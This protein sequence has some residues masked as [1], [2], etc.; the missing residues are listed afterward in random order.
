VLPIE[1]DRLILR[2]LEVGDRDWLVALYA[3]SGGS[4]DDAARELTEALEH[5]RAHGYGHVVAELRDGGERVAV[6]ELHRAGEG[7][8]GIA[9]DEVEIGWLVAPAH[10]GVGVATEAARAVSGF[11][12]DQLGIEHL[13]A[14]VRPA[15]AASR[16]V[17]EKI[18]M[19]RRG[20]GRS[21]SGAE[22]EIFELRRPV[23][24]RRGVTPG[25]TPG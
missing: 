5:E 15:N 8:V 14:Y 24:R 23:G 25:R 3:A 6:V 18:G 22:V 11:A 13:V 16:R 2:P 21:R 19:R 17:V 10:R 7:V 1:T 4:R 9:P 20:S 12:L